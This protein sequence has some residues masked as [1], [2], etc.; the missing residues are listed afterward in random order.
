MITIDAT[1]ASSGIDFEGFVRGG[2][3]AEYEGGQPKWNNS[4][5]FT[6]EE[7]FFDYG[8]EASAKYVLAH[9]AAITYDFKSTH[10][11]YG[12]VE[13]LEFGTRG[14]GGFD[15][16]GYFTGGNVELKITGL[17]LGN[18]AGD[19]GGPVNAFALAYMGAGGETEFDVF[20]DALDAE[21][22]HFLGSAFDD[23]F[24]GTAFADLVEGRRGDDT[25][26]GGLGDDELYGNGGRDVLS[27]DAGSDRLV[28]GK[29]KDKLHGG[30]DADTFVFLSKGDSGRQKSLRDVIRDFSQDDGDKI[31][32][33]FK[34][35]LSFI[36]R[37]GFSGDGGEVRYSYKDKSSTIVKVDLNGDG[38][39][40]MKIGLNGKI[41][42]TEG[43]FI[44]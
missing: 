41:A 12:D 40:D 37:D 21:A 17:A 6:G 13:V 5:A 27:G 33:S 23:V 1:G 9:G 29:G 7:L 34:S 16:D 44:L 35:G 10:T 36:G 32:L 43:D 3:V 25:V 19:T 26:S 18:A 38:R 39:V 30:A 28:G 4:K 2:F 20:A 14:S 11:V 22:Q 15:A 31:D 24:T 42:L 8:S